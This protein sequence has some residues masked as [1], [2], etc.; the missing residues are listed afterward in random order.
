MIGF[1]YWLFYAVPL[2][3]T[4]RIINDR[5]G[6]VRTEVPD[7]AITA[8]LT[9][10]LVGICALWAG[11]KIRTGRSLKF[12]GLAAVDIK[13]SHMNYV[14]MVLVVCCILSL[15]ESLPTQFGEGT[16]QAITILI[17][18][19]PMLAF[20]IL[21]RNQLRGEATAVDKILIIF[22]LAVRL[23]TGLS[24][25]WLG[26]FASIILICA[27]AYIAERKRLPRLVSICAIVFILFFQVGKN[28]FRE[29][30]WRKGAQAPGRVERVTF[31]TETSLWK[32]SEVLEN[33]NSENIRLLLNPSVSRTSLLNQ[34]GNVIDKTPSI[35][36]YQ[37]GQLYSYM[38]ITLIPRAIWADKPSVNEANQFYQVAYGLTTEDDLSGTSIAVG[39]LAEGFINFG[40]PGAIA[41]MFFLG[42]L[43][44][45]F[46]RVFLSR[47]S[48][49]F[50]VAMGIVLLPPIL[51]IESQM[52]A[53]L[54]G[55][56]QQVVFSLLVFLPAIR[57]RASEIA[58]PAPELS[59]VASA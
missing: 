19:I 12:Q 47:T 32:W 42:V 45:F 59:L 33:P 13:R 41:V 29:E 24:S 36:P 49:A 11:M 56:I 2:F 1:M 58:V 16:R 15:W 35:V 10:A 30:Y 17:S 26:A 34:A 55:I 44:N 57:F 8:A 51:A 20:I 38:A 37:N 7:P 3:W 5:L 18:L 54:G 6:P 40:W 50:M 23:V 46:Q 43:F 4:D 22:F 27:A 53:Y 28:E 39:V 25:G 9:M 48:G 21:F 52:A 14:R 31:W